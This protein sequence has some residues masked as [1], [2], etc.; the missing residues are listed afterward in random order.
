[1]YMSKYLDQSQ[2]EKGKLE[3]SSDLMYFKSHTH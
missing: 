3:E 1:V 2:F